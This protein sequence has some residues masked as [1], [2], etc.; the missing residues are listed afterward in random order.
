M[1]DINF[2][3]KIGLRRLSTIRWWLFCLCLVL[4]TACVSQSASEGTNT[5]PRQQFIAVAQDVKLE[6]L[7]WG[8]SGRNVVLL[9]GGGN[10]AHV[11][12]SL[13]PKLAMQ[14][15]VFGI[16]RRGSGQSS[17][18]SS[19]YTAKQFG[20]DVVIVLDALHLTDPV[21]VGH[22]IAGEEMS[23]VSKY[24][25]GRVSALVYLDAGGS[26][27]LYNPEH[28]DIDT[29]RVELQEDLSK[30]GHNTF[31]DALITKTLADET[32]YRRNL[33]DLR[34]EVE[35]AAAPSPTVADRSSIASFQKYF[36]GYYG[37]IL[38]EDEIRQ[39]YQI[40]ATGAVGNRIG[41]P[42]PNKA[43]EIEKERFRVL[44]TRALVIIPFPDAFNIG[45]THDPAKLAAYKAQ[46]ASRKEAQIAIWRKQPNVQIVMVPNVTHY[47]FL[48]D[49]S[50]VISLITRFVNDLP[51]TS[52]PD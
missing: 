26:F 3:Q 41:H 1:I 19:G 8:G 10:T 24:H 7:D 51:R 36:T 50:E 5:H 16:T 45:V 40:T 38:P 42:I 47:I 44:D 29:D 12:A 2:S 22:S 25:P 35:G 48:S 18:P 27:A 13:A 32:R 21:L 37:G 33:Q 46:E 4:P 14:F 49:E 43:N 31:D 52:R 23:A 39:Q 20:D 6:V 9:A 15:H 34:D 11:Y 17:A 30:L 28:G